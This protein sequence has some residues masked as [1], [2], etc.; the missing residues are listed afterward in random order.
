MIKRCVN[1]ES[2][3]ENQKRNGKRDKRTH[4]HAEAGLPNLMSY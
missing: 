4:T 3:Y 1:D 2:V